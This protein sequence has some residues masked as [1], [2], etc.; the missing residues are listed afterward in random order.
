MEVG[1]LGGVGDAGTAEAFV[2]HAVVPTCGDK[3][4]FQPATRT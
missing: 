4:L 2:L 3:E 1:A